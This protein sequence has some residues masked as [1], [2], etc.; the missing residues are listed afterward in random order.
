MDQPLPLIESLLPGETRQGAFCSCVCV[1]LVLVCVVLFVLVNLLMIVGA[2][3]TVVELE[4][5][6]CE[7]IAVPTIAHHCTF[8]CAHSSTL[9][10]FS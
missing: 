2:S 6:D 5:T 9:N 4:A 8:I 7:P 3:G 1:V 10:K